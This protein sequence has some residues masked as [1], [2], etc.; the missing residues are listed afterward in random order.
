MAGEHARVLSLLVALDASAAGGALKASDF[1][2][3]AKGLDG[4]S[5]ALLSKMRTS[6]S[7]ERSPA[8]EPIERRRTLSLSV[9][10]LRPGDRL[11]DDLRFFENDRLVL[12]AGETISD[13]A[14]LKL[15]NLAGTARFQEP[16]RAERLL[17][18]KA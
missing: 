18:P 13:L 3:A 14:H 10:A 1:S 9:S 11:L 17:P 8:A 5:A 7:K 6:L 12:A 15:R 4:A 16:V 2:A